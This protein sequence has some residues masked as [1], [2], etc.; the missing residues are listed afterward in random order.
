MKKKK[1]A[2]QTLND[3]FSEALGSA[4]KDKFGCEIETVWSIVD[5]I[6]TTTKLDG[7]PFTQAEHDWIGSFE[8]GYRSAMKVVNDP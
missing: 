5:F 1:D 3:G 4:F 8:T 7:S 2:Y 6:K